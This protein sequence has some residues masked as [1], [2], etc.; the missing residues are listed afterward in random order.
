MWQIKNGNGTRTLE[1]LNFRVTAALGVE[2]P[3][4]EVIT[5]EFGLAD[6]SLFQRVVAKERVFQLVGVLSGHPAQGGNFEDLEEARQALLDE[7]S[8]DAI[9]SLDADGD[10]VITPL[11]LQYVLAGNTVE[12]ECIPTGKGLEGGDNDGGGTE[13]LAIEFIAADPFWRNPTAITV[14]LTEGSNTTVT[15]EGTTKAFPILTLVGEGNIL[16]L[17][18]DTIGLTI[19]FDNLS[20]FSGET[21]TLD[22]TPGEKS[23][24]SDVRGNLNGLIA[25]GVR[26]TTWHLA[27]GENTILLSGDD[28]IEILDQDGNQI[29]DENGDPI[30]AAS[31]LSLSTAD[32]SFN[33]RHWALSGATR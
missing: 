31:G 23:L 11:K 25:Q 15:N 29:Q 19:T 22:L 6:G 32:L 13:K 17:A 20:V 18:N 26:L 8:R 12:I 27:P 33:K 16:S 28:D 24:T 1:S 4:Q 30:L 5:T 10:E 21:L 14:A 7:L 2:Y 9:V 3:P